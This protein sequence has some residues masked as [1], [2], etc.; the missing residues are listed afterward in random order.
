MDHV[1]I[2]CQYI[3]IPNGLNR[4]LQRNSD[5]P[6]PSSL[7]GWLGLGAKTTLQAPFSYNMI[8]FLMRT[9][10]F[11]VEKQLAS[12]QLHYRTNISSLRWE[13]TSL[14]LLYVGLKTSLLVQISCIRASFRRRSAGLVLS[15]DQAAGWRMEADESS[16]ILRGGERTKSSEQSKHGERSS[17]GKERETT[18]WT[19]QIYS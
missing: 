8:I 11:L 16:L 4:L 15:V 13:K 6:A 9:G 19:Q 1:L 10:L 7:Y 3:R 17:N 12:C 18:L 5:T 14:C 2:E